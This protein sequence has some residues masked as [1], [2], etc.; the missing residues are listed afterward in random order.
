[1][2]VWRM[3]GINLQVSINTFA[4]QLRK[5]GFMAS[6][7]QILS[8][9]PDVPP[10]QLLIEITETALLP[11]LPVVQQIITDCQQ[12]GVGFSIDDFGT[13]YSSLV[14]LRHLSAMELKIDQ[15]FVRDMLTNH[16]DQDIIEGIIALGRL[17]QRSVIAEGV[18]TI[19]QIHRLLELGCE[20]MQGY[21]IARP[22]PSEQ[23]MTW[24]RDFQHA[25][26]GVDI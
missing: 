12:L 6:L 19:E 8:E 18:E 13:G 16:A 14:Y 22:M 9:Y 10:S 7:Q 26:L 5:P 3:E 20:A 11:E 23:I 24:A 1:M 2:Q 15:G 17:F 21:G 25:Q 4:R